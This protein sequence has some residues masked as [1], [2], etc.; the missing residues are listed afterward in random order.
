MGWKAVRAT[1]IYATMK[2]GV[3]EGR[4]LL[5]PSAGRDEQWGVDA[6]WSVHLLSCV[7]HKCLTTEAKTVLPAAE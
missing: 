6:E 4:H 7:A 3:Q 1:P 5:K 2:S